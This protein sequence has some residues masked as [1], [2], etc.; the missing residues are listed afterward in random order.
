MVTERHPHSNGVAM[1]ISVLAGTRDESAEIAGVSHFLEHL[2]FKGTKT[3]SS[4]QIARSLEALG[5]DLNAYTTREYTNYHSLVL[6]KYWK[7]SLL[8]LSDLVS[9][10]SINKSDLDVE[11]SVVLQE[12]DMSEDQLEDIVYDFYLEEAFKG[13]PLGKQIL[14]EKQTIQNMTLKQVKQYYESHYTGSNLIV[15][16]TGDI[17]HEELTKLAEQLLG[18]KKKLG[19]L[20]KR[21]KPSQK[22]I[23][24][25]LE[26][27]SEQ[28]HILL[29]AP[30]TSFKDK[31]RFEAYIVNTLLGGGMTSKLYQSIREKKGL[32]Y[33]IHSS[34]NSFTDC[35]N[36]FIHGATDT[37]KVKTV[38][39]LISKE[40]NRLRTHGI[41]KADLKL[42][43]TQVIG[44]IILGSEDIENRLSSIAV[45]EMVFEKYKSTEEV[46]EEIER[47]SV[48]SVNAYIENFLK[49]EKFGGLIMGKG[50]HSLEQWWLETE[51]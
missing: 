31:L 25:V 19:T 27:P 9:N 17:D 48:D 38:V 35:G 23:R 1:G 39:D 29:G 51:L 46:I 28:V 14:G 3:R 50:A 42:F 49:S 40:L 32:V 43:K 47:V 11:K 26:K 41:T 36:L 18:S 15:S 24:K 33:S 6:K 5:G 44:S 37:A 34:L 4:Y 12:I 10:M 7:E 13:N 30:A 20:P 8:V 2:V 22:M 21:K 45:N 16:A